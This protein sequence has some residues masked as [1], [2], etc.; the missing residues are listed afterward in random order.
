MQ[1]GA[2][3]QHKTGYTCDLRFSGRRPAGF[4]DLLFGEGEQ[5]YNAGRTRELWKGDQFRKAD[6][7]GIRQGRLE[8]VFDFERYLW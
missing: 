1:S 4:S 5:I 6:I 2:T 8:A 3:I 7:Q